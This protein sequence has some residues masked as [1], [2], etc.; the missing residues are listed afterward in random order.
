MTKHGQRCS[1]SLLGHGEYGCELQIFHQDDFTYGRR[2]VTRELA[3]AEGE[4]WRRELEAK[5][6]T[7]GGARGDR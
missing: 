5:G 7:V 1:V 6:W 2:H 3:I 4:A